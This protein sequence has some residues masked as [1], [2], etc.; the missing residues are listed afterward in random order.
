MKACA[1]LCGCNSIYPI[2]DRNVRK[3]MGG[4]RESIVVFPG[5]FIEA[6]GSTTAGLRLYAGTYAYW[7]R[8]CIEF[9]YD[10]RVLCVY[11]GAEIYQQS[12]FLLAQRLAIA[13]RGLP[14]ILPA[15]PRPPPKLAV[16]ELLLHPALTE[17]D[18]S[19]HSPEERV[20]ARAETLCTQLCDE[21]ARAHVQDAEAVL[22]ATGT[23]P[24]AMTIRSKL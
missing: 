24:R 18:A 21:I 19:G 22:A 13:K 14:G 16:R 5:G 11:H 1:R 8:R 10:L 4:S 7:I 20:R 6:A 23:R 2:G 15:L 17:G 3:V 12:D 9:D